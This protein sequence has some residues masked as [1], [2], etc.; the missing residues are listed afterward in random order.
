MGGWVSSNQSKV[1][2]AKAR[3]ERILSQDCNIEILPEFPVRLVWILNLPVNSLKPIN[4]SISFEPCL[5]QRVTEGYP[6]EC[7]IGP[8]E[9]YF[10]PS[11]GHFLD[12]FPN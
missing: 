5:M 4:Q 9:M 1:F 12:D 10:S 11:I 3:E 7:G 6:G 8:K 2:K